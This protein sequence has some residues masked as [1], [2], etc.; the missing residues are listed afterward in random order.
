MSIISFGTGIAFAVPQNDASGAAVANATPVQFGELQD[1]TLDISFEE[2]LLYGSKKFPI[3]MGQGKGKIGIK[4]KTATING[5]ILGDLVFGS[6]ST[7]GIRAVVQNA[8]SAVPAVTPYTIAAVPP[9]NGTW[10]SGLGL[11]NAATGKPMTCVASNPVSGQYSVNNGV[12]TFAAADAGLSI[13]MS[14]EYSATSTTGKVGQITNQL[15]GYAPSFK[16]ALSNN[17]KN[18]NLTIVLNYCTASKL[19][20]PFKNDDFSIPDLDISAFDGNA[21]IGYWAIQEA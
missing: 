18:N 16:L 11:L 6:G 12:Y 2:K 13:L 17:F 8:P 9:N 1:V 3:A 15:M 7:A 21:G 10:V 4:A 20:F 14:Y 5:A 19:S